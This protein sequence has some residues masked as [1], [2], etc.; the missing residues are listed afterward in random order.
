MPNGKK[1]VGNSLINIDDKKLLIGL[2]VVFLIGTLF[3]GNLTGNAGKVKFLTEFDSNEFNLLEGSVQLYK[4]NVIKLERVSEN[5]AI[6]VGVITD[7]SDEQRI[8]QAGHRIYINGHYITNINTNYAQKRA[9]L[10]VE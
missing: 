10:R 3:S 9:V 4:G 6:V 2:F 1:V 5:G 7:Y 8:V